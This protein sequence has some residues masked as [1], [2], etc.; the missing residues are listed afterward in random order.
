MANT[1]LFNARISLR[2]GIIM[3]IIIDGLDFCQAV[4]TAS[5]PSV[6]GILVYKD[7]TSNETKYESSIMLL[8]FSIF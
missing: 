7:R 3:D 1:I 4:F 8:T 6:Y 2:N 5:A